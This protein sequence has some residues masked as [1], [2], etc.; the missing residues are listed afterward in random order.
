M[1]NKKGELNTIAAN[2]VSFSYSG[3]GRNAVSDVSFSA[4]PGEHIA[5]VGPNGSGKTTLFQIL[6]GTFRPDKGEA[7]LG[8]KNIRKYPVLER[9]RH[10]AYVPQGGRINFPYTC[11]ELTL[12]GLHPH[13]TLSTFTEESA[14]SRAEE[15]MRETGAWRFAAKSVNTLSG[16]E[17]QLALLTRAL[18]QMFPDSNESPPE[19]SAS[20]NHSTKLLLLDEAFS[21][22]DIAARISM[23]KLLNR[24]L[25][26]R[27]FTIIGI[28]HDLHLANRF[29][30]R[31]IALRQG[32]I[33]GDGPPDA[34]FTQEFFSGVFGV[35]AEIIPNKGFF[36]HDEA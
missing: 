19:H 11:L 7:L 10:I 14:L 22:L 29:A 8:R 4:G 32:R 33:A 36:F 34:I 17:L 16:G 6:N 5:L 15:I 27:C 20:A 31:V 21:E 23:M 24:T 9:A 1:E 3:S 28:H 13:K 25:E 18:R 26:K 2:D 35:Q 12:M 30:S